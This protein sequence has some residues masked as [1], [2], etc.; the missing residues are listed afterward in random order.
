MSHSQLD[1]PARIGQLKAEPPSE[2]ECQGLLQSGLHRLEDAGR[3]VCTA[4]LYR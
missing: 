4:Q 3:F 1:N 2:A